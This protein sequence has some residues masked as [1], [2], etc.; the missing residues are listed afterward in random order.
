[1]THESTHGKLI[2]SFA[3]YVLFSVEGGIGITFLKRR[4]EIE[5]QK[6]NVINELCSSTRDKH[7]IKITPEI[8]PFILYKLPLRIFFAQAEIFEVTV[9]TNP[10]F[11]ILAILSSSK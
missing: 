4:I 11:S 1:M 8:H 5:E 9:S 10:V 3:L 6:F 7:L 2:C